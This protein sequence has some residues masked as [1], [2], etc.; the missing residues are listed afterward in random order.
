M[1]QTPTKWTDIVQKRKENTPPEDDRPMVTK[2]Q[3][4]RNGD[5]EETPNHA[6]CNEGHHTE[7]TRD[8]T[9][10]IGHQKEREEDA[11]STGFVMAQTTGGGNDEEE[12]SDMK[13]DTRGRNVETTATT[14][15]YHGQENEQ[16]EEMDVDKTGNGQQQKEVKVRDG[17]NIPQTSNNETM[18]H[19]TPMSP[20]RLKKNKGRKETET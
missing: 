17:S 2:I 6:P 19:H 20:K 4:V 16:H 7:K 11:V 1:E 12:Q 10:G 9:N 5:N 3:E 15:T 8:I 13:G 18:R 14:S